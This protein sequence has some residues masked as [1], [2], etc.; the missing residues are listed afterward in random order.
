[1]SNVKY[2]LLEN[3]YDAS[4]DELC[5][6]IFEL[7]KTTDHVLARSEIEAVCREHGAVPRTASA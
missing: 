1:M 2:W 7:A 4:D 6:R 3:G 5:H